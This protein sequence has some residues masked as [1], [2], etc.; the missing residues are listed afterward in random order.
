MQ[1]PAWNRCLLL[2]DAMGTLVKLEPPVEPLRRELE[3]RFGVR[4]SMREAERAIA[5]EITY[6]RTHM[7]DGRDPAGVAALRARC[8][9]ALR[10]AL[11]PSAGLRDVDGE[12]LTEALL[13]SLRFSAF[14][15]ASAALGSARARGQR[16]IVV[17]NWDSS[18]SHVL[19]RVGLASL[20]DRVITSAEVGARKPAAAVFE[21]ALAA[22]RVTP[23]QALHVGD[24]LEEDVAGA[25]AA[26]IAALW[27]NRD[28]AGAPPG[29]SMIRSLDE[30]SE[31]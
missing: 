12:A 18:L 15:D 10:G 23:A 11:P 13:A 17:S 2:L 6:Y 7:D 20:L 5:A 3:L 16:V 21:A 14:P 8:A 30:L 26:G 31:N 1:S 27:L 28:G 4:V 22:A 25:R 19:E 9:E 29:V 24:S